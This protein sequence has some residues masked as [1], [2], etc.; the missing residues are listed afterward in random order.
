MERTLQW[1]NKAKEWSVAKQQ[2]QVYYSLWA[3]VNEKISIQLICNDHEFQDNV[4][5]SLNKTENNTF[6]LTQ[7]VQVL[8]HLHMK[9]CM[10]PNMQGPLLL[11][12]ISN[13]IHCKV[14][15]DMTYAFPNL[16]G[17]AF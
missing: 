12:W 4:I 14:W 13:Y 6:W 5:T 9:P 16:N 15:D 1:S 7:Y 8:Y 2:F 3:Q 17:A 10:E 11:I